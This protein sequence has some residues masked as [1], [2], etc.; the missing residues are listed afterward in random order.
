MKHSRKYAMFPAVLATI[1][2][3][4]GMSGCKKDE[5]GGFEVP[6]E[7]PVELDPFA[8][9][10]PKTHEVEEVGE[11]PPDRRLEGESETAAENETTAI[12]EE[13]TGDPNATPQPT[14]LTL[15]IKLLPLA[16]VE[17]QFEA[18]RDGKMNDAA[19]DNWIPEESS[20]KKMLV[21]R[22]KS[23]AKAAA[24]GELTIAGVDQM[25]AGNWAVVPVKVDAVKDGKQL[26][27]ISEQYLVLTDQGWK[28]APTYLHDD[29]KLKLLVDADFQK[30]AD[31]YKKNEPRLKQEW[32][33]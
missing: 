3:I 22:L 20:L 13:S 24:A 16:V 14:T 25:M 6:L 11:A 19:N 12:D 30:V 18:L 4:G 32:L 27:G 23:V 2:I 15:Q 33:K 26:Q 8:K 17:R 5:S 28:I 7:G 10:P 1:A 29:P 31:W 9:G 21:G